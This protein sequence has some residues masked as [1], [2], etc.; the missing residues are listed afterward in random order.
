MSVAP[1]VSNELL[2]SSDRAKST[3]K[4]I[5][6]QEIHVRKT[7]TLRQLE[8]F[9]GVEYSTLSSYMSGEKE[10]SLSRAMSIVLAL[11]PRAVACLCGMIDYVSYPSDGRDPLDTIN[12]AIRVLSEHGRVA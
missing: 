12:E 10:P 5:L 7:M 6:H 3:I 9:S 11:G 8:Q 2:I 1:S 4:T